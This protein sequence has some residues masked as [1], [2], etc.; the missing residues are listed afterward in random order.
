MPHTKYL[1]VVSNLKKSCGDV[2]Y[3]IRI[4]KIVEER[5]RVRMN[6][7]QINAI[8]GLLASGYAYYVESQL[9]RGDSIG[10]SL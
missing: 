9:S 6:G 2:D 8:L 5:E 1:L 3:K 7:I 4:F 10:T